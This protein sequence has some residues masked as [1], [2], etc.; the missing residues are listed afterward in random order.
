MTFGDLNGQQRRGDN[1]LSGGDRTAVERLGLVG[2]F[3]GKDPFGGDAGIDAEPERSRVRSS[4][5][6]RMSATES[7][8]G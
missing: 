1:A 2:Q 4:R 6:V 8:H 3:L 5:M 7:A